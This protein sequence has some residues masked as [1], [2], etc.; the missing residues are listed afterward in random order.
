MNTPAINQFQSSINVSV[1]LFPGMLR[2]N[3]AI[4]LY[5][6]AMEK[7][8]VIV[9]YEQ[10]FIEVVHGPS[11]KIAD[12]IQVDT[13]TNDN[14]L[15]IERRG[16]G[17]T[18]VLSPGMCITTITGIREDLDA[19]GIFHRIHSAMIQLLEKLGIQGLGQQGISDI[20]INGQKILGS[21]LY[22]GTKPPYYYYQSSLMVSSDIHLLNRYLKHPPKEPDYRNNRSHGSFCTTLLAKG[23]T[24]NAKTICKLFEEEL[25]Y[26]LR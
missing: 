13:C 12:E 16:G 9:S 10:D 7:K 18:V 14:V 24:I 4:F 5:G 21:S 15:I 25:F 20:T 2:K 8:P 26:L 23:Y 22:L 19:L 1:P 6:A 11:C 17:G 3:D